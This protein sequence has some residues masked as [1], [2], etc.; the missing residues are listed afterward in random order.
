MS[1]KIKKL[2]LQNQRRG[3]IGADLGFT[4]LELIVAIGILTLVTTLS[5][6]NYRGADNSNSLQLEA[7]KIVADL[8]QLQNMALS[9]SEFDEAVPTGGWGISYTAGTSSYYLFADIDGGVDYDD[10]SELY[11][12]VELKNGI[13]FA[14]GSSGVIAFEPPDPIINFSGAAAEE[15]N[16]AITDGTLTKTI[17]VN[18]LGL[19]DVID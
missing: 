4:L 15:K 13:Q 5:L 19:I 2:F 12:T 10:A 17:N 3:G 8:R 11:R 14:A 18:I 9:A 1:I 6:A 16:I 7:Y